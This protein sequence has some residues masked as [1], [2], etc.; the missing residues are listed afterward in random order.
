MQECSVCC[1][2]LGGGGKLPDGC[3]NQ[4]RNVKPFC[5]ATL[6]NKGECFQHSVLHSTVWNT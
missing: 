6:E 2:V 1:C 5:F 4:I 3:S